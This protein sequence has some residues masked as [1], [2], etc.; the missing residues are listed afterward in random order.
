M[1]A[2]SRRR[3]A[4]AGHLNAQRSSLSELAS[5]HELVVRR[6]RRARSFDGIGERALV[7]TAS[8]SLEST[9]RVAQGKPP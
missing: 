4:S 7:S 8:P 5:A 3:A 6:E 1:T 9:G 2:G